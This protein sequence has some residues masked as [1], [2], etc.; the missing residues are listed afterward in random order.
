MKQNKYFNPGRFA[1]LFR[2][3][4][5]INQKT[6]LFAIAGL[7]IAIYAILYL[8]KITNNG[9]S[10]PDPFQYYIPYFT[11]Y[12]IIIGAFIG[13]SFQ[14]FNNQT[15]TNNYLL[16]PGSTFEKYLV[17]LCI[18]VFIFIPLALAI[19]W[20]ATYL[21]KASM[22]PYPKTNFDP[23]KIPNF[24]FIDLFKY[25]PKFTDKLVTV[26]SIFSFTTV[27]FAG[28]AWFNRFALVKTLIAT[29]M[30]IGMVVM[31]FVLFS[32]VFYPDVV[33]GFDIHIGSYK[34]TEDLK[35]TQLAFY[36]LGSLAWLFFLPLAYFKLKEKEV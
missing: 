23:S 31:T 24:H 34:I 13:M 7:S 26:F 36:L 22:I 11:M 25:I 1:R 12:T 2:N 29:G 17:Q 8:F 30:T 28:S 4:L 16:T 18:R 19:F 32:H 10:N 14:F 20:I 3:D 6:Y 5:L 9:Y 33:H 35:N 21:A 15:K 27:L